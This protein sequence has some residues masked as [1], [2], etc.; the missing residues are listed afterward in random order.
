MLPLVALQQA[1]AVERLSLIPFSEGGVLFRRG[2]RKIWALNHSAAVIWS[3]AVENPTSAYITS[4][5]VSMY[6]ISQLQALSDAE[7]VLQTLFA[8]NLLGLD[9]SAKLAPDDDQSPLVQD[10][11]DS[12]QLSPHQGL[13]KYFFYTPGHL[14]QLSSVEHPA[15]N[16]YARALQAFSV[17]FTDRSPDRCIFLLQS[18]DVCSTRYN[19]FINTMC[20]ANDLR[21][22]D[23]VPALLGVTFTSVADSLS[24]RLL[25]H[26]AVLEKNH[27]AFLF[28]G[29]AGNGKTIL[30]ATLACR[31]YNFFA[32][33]L[34]LLNPINGQIAPLPLPMSIKPGA[35]P[36]L[37][38]LYPELDHLPVYLRADGKNVKILP[39][40]LDCEFDFD[41]QAKPAAIVFP[42]YD[43]L[44][45]TKITP[46]SKSETISRLV[47]LCSSSRP[48][49][50][51]DI[52]AMVR[53]V[54][55]NPCFEV[56][57]ADLDTVYDL[58]E[59]ISLKN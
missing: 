42:R 12:L 44:V 34:A 27:Q 24:D 4:R 30:A 35:V 32:D 31:G 58:L 6:G 37:R 10:V 1:K 53:L 38:H 51:Q 22:Q 14:I 54:D 20:Y 9:D 7:T 21:E 36:V 43:S 48:L 40:H 41:Q 59:Q 25:F 18:T 47:A 29:E 50:E 39:P 55:E 8:E 11:R 56:V 5:L 16:E 15:V 17:P 33:E 19:I 23:I 49:V 45:P 52:A 13:R 26:A 2:T 46:L 3:L 28:P 57:Y